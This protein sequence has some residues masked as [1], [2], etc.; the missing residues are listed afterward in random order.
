MRISD[1]SSDVCASDLNTLHALLRQLG[2]HW[3]IEAGDKFLVPS[4]ISH[5]GGSI[6]AFESPLLLGT[7]AVVMDK[8]D[9]DEAVK[10]IDAESITHMAGATPFLE[11][12]LAAAERA[13]PHLPSLKV[14]IC[15]GASVQP[16]T[17]RRSE[18][19]TTD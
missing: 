18:E 9:A 19:H 3:L 5:I 10:L 4:P 11:A 7:T 14:F 2:E 1:W 12:L 13:G 15:G 17:I 6:Y 16:H 8:W